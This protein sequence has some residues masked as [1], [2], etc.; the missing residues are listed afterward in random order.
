MFIWDVTSGETIRRISGHMTKI[1][2]VEFNKDATVVASGMSTL[3]LIISLF[4]SISSVALIVALRC[5]R[6]GSYDSTVKL[7]DLRCALMYSFTASFN[8]DFS[9][10][11][12]RTDSPS[13][14]WKKRGTLFRRFTSVPQSSCLAQSTVTSVHTTFARANFARTT[15]DVRIFSGHLFHLSLNL[16]SFL[17]PGNIHRPDSRRVDVS[18]HHARRTHSTHGCLQ[19]KDAQ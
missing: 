1:N 15:S 6:S 19:R 13:S 12:P 2:V 11:D 5:H 17:R 16:C 7:W 18:R 4:L 10:P 8:V 9:N 14:R 3:S